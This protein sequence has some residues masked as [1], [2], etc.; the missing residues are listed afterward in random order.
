M[1][2]TIDIQYP[3]RKSG[4]PTEAKTQPYSWRFSNAPCT[5]PKQTELPAVLGFAVLNKTF[6]QQGIF[7]VIHWNSWLSVFFLVKNPTSCF[8][9]SSLAGAA[10]PKSDVA[11]Q[12][13]II[14]KPRQ[15]KLYHME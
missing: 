10:A 8:P 3:H 6:P 11:S 2:E 13:L 15:V 5:P 12:E 4:V 9:Y 14:T 1:F 7:R